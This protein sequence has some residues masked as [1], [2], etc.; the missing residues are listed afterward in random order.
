MYWGPLEGHK[1]LKQLSFS[2]PRK[3]IFAPLGVTS[4]GKTHAVM[5]SKY[6]MARTV[7]MGW[8]ALPDPSLSLSIF[9]SNFVVEEMCCVSYDISPR[10]HLLTA[11]SRCGLHVP[12]SPVFPGPCWLDSLVW[13]SMRIEPDKTGSF[14]SG[15][16]HWIS[17]SGCINSLRVSLPFKWM[18]LEGRKFFPFFPFRFFGW[19]SHWRKADQQEKNKCNFI[20]WEL[21]KLCALQ[22]DK[23]R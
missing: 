21:L 9:K 17:Q 22:S 8:C 13:I 3:T 19:S 15:S 16:R 23:S 20:L 1:P 12:R 7:A 10:L 5:W 11:A 18:I 4:T 14:L 6:G 2:T